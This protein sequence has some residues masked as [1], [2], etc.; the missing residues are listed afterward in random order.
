MVRAGSEK[1]KRN[2]NTFHLTEANET[3]LRMMV[4]FIKKK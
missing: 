3:N 4:I 2:C 1:K